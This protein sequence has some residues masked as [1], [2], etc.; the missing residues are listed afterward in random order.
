MVFIV[1]CCV[2]LGVAVRRL[3]CVLARSCVLCAVCC[4]CCVFDVWRV[5]LCGVRWLLFVAVHV[6]VVVVCGL[7]CVV[8]LCCCW[9]LLLSVF[10]VCC[11]CLLFVA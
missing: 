11:R 4:R 1:C 8:C 7:L 5:A 2:L 10:V 9:C 6:V 3:Y